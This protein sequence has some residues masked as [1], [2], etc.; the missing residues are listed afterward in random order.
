[1]KN[2]KILFGLAFVLV[3]LFSCSKESD[4]TVVEESVTEGQNIELRKKGFPCGR[5]G[6][7]VLEHI[8]QPQACWGYGFFWWNNKCIVCH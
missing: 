8:T 6:F 1:M 2:F 5:T 3:F 7:D 4:L